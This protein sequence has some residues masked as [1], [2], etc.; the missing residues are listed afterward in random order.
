M[1]FCCLWQA[2]I[3]EKNGG[4]GCNVGEDGGLAPDISRYIYFSFLMLI[5]LH[6]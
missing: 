5:C 1:I 4:L 2:V 6:L 3:A